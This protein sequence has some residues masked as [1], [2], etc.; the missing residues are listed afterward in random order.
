MSELKTMTWKEIRR[1]VEPKALAVVPV[2]SFEQHGPHLPVETD[3]LITS[4]VAIA[5]DQHL[6]EK[7]IK[8]YLTPTLWLGC[9]PHHLDLFAIS[10]NPALYAQVLIN[11][12]DSLLSAGF[13]RIFFLNGHGGNSALAQVA[14]NT[15]ALKSKAL[16]GCGA[17]WELARETIRELRESSPQGMAH[18]GELE[19]SLMQYLFPSLVKDELAAPCYPK[20]PPQAAID[21]TDAGPLRF[22][23]EFSE[24]NPEGNL[25][26][27]SL[28]SS[29]K[30]RRFF[31]AI[32]NA[33]ADQLAEFVKLSVGK[34][35]KVNHSQ[36]SV[37]GG[38][39]DE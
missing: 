31:M 16:I 14:M 7:G 37:L 32:V 26:D 9:S 38:I 28:A 13:Q 23:M 15:L 30:G 12:G 27:P 36:N 18:A 11:I 20:L 5:V 2:A 33:V 3:T 6:Q 8:S 21:M 35:A 1:V 25:G 4:K 34:R 22:G 39:N 10:L 24:L 29:E 19:T 17:Y